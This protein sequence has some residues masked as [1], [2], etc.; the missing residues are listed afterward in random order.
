MPDSLSNI[1]HHTQYMISGVDMPPAV[2][3]SFIISFI[4]L[5]A[6]AIVKY[7]IAKNSNVIDWGEMALELPIDICAIIATII[8][9]SKIPVE[10]NMTL[11]SLSAFLPILLCGYFRRRTLQCYTNRSY[12]AILFVCFDYGTAFLWIK[13]V[14]NLIFNNY[15]G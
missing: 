4:V 10:A 13:I 9:S 5:L 7:T 12:W 3:Q 8:A 2:L 14:V 15:V 6:A 1:L 11:Y